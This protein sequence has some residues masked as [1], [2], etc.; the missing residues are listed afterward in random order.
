MTKYYTTYKHHLITRPCDENARM[1]TTH[2]Q[3]ERRH[4]RRRRDARAYID[5]V[6]EGRIPWPTG[7]SN[8]KLYA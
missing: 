4:H 8:Q 7:I 5:A 2:I 1:W 3:G 6:E